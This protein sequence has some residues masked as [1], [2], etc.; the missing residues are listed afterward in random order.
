[1][2]SYLSVEQVDR[3]STNSGVWSDKS[4]SLHIT[5]TYLKA[6]IYLSSPVLGRVRGERTAGVPLP[7]VNH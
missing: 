5:F 1:M 3:T 2:L 7:V 6:A 4:A